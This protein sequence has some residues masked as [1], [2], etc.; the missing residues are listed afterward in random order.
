VNKNLILS[1]D[2]VHGKSIFFIEVPDELGRRGAWFFKLKV[3]SIVFETPGAN[4]VE[5]QASFYFY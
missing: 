3:S 4:S 5:F 2:F 1:N